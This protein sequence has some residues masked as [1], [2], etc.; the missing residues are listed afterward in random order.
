MTSTTEIT[1]DI[2]PIASLIGDDLRTRSF[3][4][5]DIERLTI[6]C[7]HIATLD[8]NGV[9]F[10]S[11]SVADELCEILNEYPLMDIAGMTGDVKKMYDI[12]VKGRMSPRVY[13]DV[14][15][16]VVHLKTMKDME[17]FFSTF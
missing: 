10:V 16:E 2:L 7:N 4:R 15:V 8:F 13:S 6:P 12:V 1:N 11:R 17:E 9:K 5:R 3:F 14:N